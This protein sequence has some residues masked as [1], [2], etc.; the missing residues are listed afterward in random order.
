[1]NYVF[2]DTCTWINFAT[3]KDANSVFDYTDANFRL[4][5]DLF[6]LKK[7]KKIIFLKNEII[8]IEFKSASVDALIENYDK[9]I[10]SQLKN[11][12]SFKIIP[13]C[14]DNKIRNILNQA[15]MSLEE[16]LEPFKNLS[17]EFNKNVWSLYNDAIQINV[18]E[19]LKQKALMYSINR[20]H[21]FFENN[22]NNIN[23]FLILYSIQEWIESKKELKNLDE[24]N[25]D[26]G[27]Y[28]VTRNTKDFGIDTKGN[29][30]GD[31]NI[32]QLIKP[33][34]NLNELIINIKNKQ[35]NKEDFL[36]Y[37]SYQNKIE[38]PLELIIEKLN[39]LIKLKKEFFLSFL[40]NEFTSIVATNR[41]KNISQVLT[42][43]HEIL[44]E[45]NF[46]TIRSQNIVNGKLVHDELLMIAKN[47]NNAITKKGD[48]LICAYGK[49]AGEHCVNILEYEAYVHKSINIIRLDTHLIN[50]KYFDYFLRQ[51]NINKIIFL[52]EPSY[53]ARINISDL[54][55]VSINLPSLEKQ[56]NLVKLFEEKER[57]IE[58]DILAIKRKI[59]LLII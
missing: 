6:E 54:K 14:D 19:Q 38:S 56:K 22:K 39:Y 21:L 24:T 16:I 48:I 43:K 41:I 28:F 53:M 3:G 52:N 49:K 1:M 57:E 34:H 4:L 40:N 33:I 50:V 23:D 32:S 9:N 20:N 55:N 51:Y 8:D 26:H 59:K 18:S 27:I 30:I 13:H 2:L 11:N 44:K 17:I 15:F 58:R 37:N 35:N 10:I 47:N 25:Q 29:F 12:L 5:E 45:G 31:V 42:S 46:P 36:L 7:S